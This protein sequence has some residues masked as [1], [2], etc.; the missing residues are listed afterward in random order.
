LLEERVPSGA[1]DEWFIQ[2]SPAKFG[3]YTAARLL[4]TLPPR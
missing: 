2:N 1:P 3:Q 4:A